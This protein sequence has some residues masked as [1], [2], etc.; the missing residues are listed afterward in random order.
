VIFIAGN[1]P[2]VSEIAP[3][4]III[5]LEEFDYAGATAVAT[6]MLIISFVL[7]LLINL[8]QGWSRSRNAR[9]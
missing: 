6:A 8:L 7:L 2:F 5:K 1:L 3:L 9:K 4:L